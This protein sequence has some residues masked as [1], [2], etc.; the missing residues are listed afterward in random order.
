LRQNEVQMMKQQRLLWTRFG[1]TRHH[2]LAAVGSRKRHVQHLN[3]SQFFQHCPRRQSGSLHLQSMP[4]RHRQT[5]SEE[6]NQDVRVYPTLQLMVDR[7]DAQ[8]APSSL[9]LG[10]VTFSV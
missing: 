6:G 7:P 4:Q 5:V 9:S 10:A 8:I 2:Q 1:V 3:A